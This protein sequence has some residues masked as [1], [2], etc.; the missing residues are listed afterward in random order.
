M[1]AWKLQAFHK[2][3][4]DWNVEEASAYLLK[5]AT[6]LRIPIFDSFQATVQVNFDR[7]NN[8]AAGAK[9][10]DYEYLLTGGYTW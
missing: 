3:T 9:K 7:N 2:H 4:L 1:E 10:D 8:P 5:T 6:G